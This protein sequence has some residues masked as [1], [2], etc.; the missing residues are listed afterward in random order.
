MRPTSSV[1]LVRASHPRRSRAFAASPHSASTSVGRKYRSSIA[2]VSVPL[3]ARQPEGDLAQLAHGVRLAGGDD[4]VVGLVLLEHEP[5]GLD[6]VR[7]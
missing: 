4:V 1:N 2:D 6:V 7:A 3:E 5:H